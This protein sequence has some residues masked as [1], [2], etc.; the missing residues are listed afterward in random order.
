MTLRRSLGAALLA[1]VL[2]ATT[3]GCGVLDGL[4]RH[5]G[6]RT[7]STASATSPAKTVAERLAQSHL[8][9]RLNSRTAQ[10]KSGQGAMVVATTGTDIPDDIV[11]ASTAAAAAVHRLDKHASHNP[12][13]ILVPKDDAQY[14]AFTGQSVGR[15]LASTVTRSG[16]LP[17]VVLAPWIVKNPGTTTARETVVHEAF[18]A[19]TLENLPT[20]RPL[21][22][23]E[24]WAEYV[25]Q[26]TVPQAPHKRD[27]ITAHVPSDEELRGSNASDAYY[28]AFTFARYLRDTYGNDKVMA[29]YTEAV[30]TTTPL[31]TLL[32][33]SFGAG[34]DALEGRC[35]AWYP[36][37]R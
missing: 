9:D 3:S 16:V 6:T 28:A 29:F 18:H 14:K 37:F 33:R 31:E 13:L 15:Q 19:L 12:L 34:I 21:W 22:L 11:T 2:G 10:E 20:K 35:A 8:Q 4:A 1:V 27:D 24:G 5:S 30:T 17:Y 23:L 32:T 26:R 36:R 7:T 25:G